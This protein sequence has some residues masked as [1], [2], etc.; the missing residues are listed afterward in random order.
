[1][2]KVYFL[3]L[4]LGLFLISCQSNKRELTVIDYYVEDELSIDALQIRYRAPK[5]FFLVDKQFTD[6]IASAELLADAF[7]PHILSIHVDTLSGA[8]M[9]ISDVRYI[10]LQRLN[11]NIKEYKTAFNQHNTWQTMYRQKIKT[12]HFDIT[13]ISSEN[14]SY[15]LTKLFFYEEKRPIF[16]VDYFLPINDKEKYT[17][18]INSSIASFQKGYTIIFE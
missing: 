8:T 10:P 1:M 9:M 11:K 4:V 12:E 2:K 17:P 3:V 14:E 6:S 16:V 5:G 15:L 7:A 13:E 18:L